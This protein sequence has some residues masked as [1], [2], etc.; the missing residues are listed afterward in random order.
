MRFRSLG[1][2]SRSAATAAVCASLA[3]FLLLAA[4]AP[5]ALDGGD[6]AVY[7]Q[8][9]ERGDFAQRTVHIGYYFAV[10][11]LTGFADQL[12]DRAFNWTSAAFA[13]GILG[14]LVLATVRLALDPT[15]AGGERRLDPS[16]Q[17]ASVAIAA[18]LASAAVLLGSWT[19]VRQALY[20]EVYGAQTFF[21]VLALYLWWRSLPAAGPALGVA[22]RVSPSSALAVLG[23]PALRA[24][25]RRLTMMATTT[26]ATLALV[27]AFVW[28]DFFFSDR[29]V[30][31]AASAHLGLKIAV[32]KEGFELVF[33]VFALLPFLFVG[34]LTLVLEPRRRRWLLVLGAIW[35]PTFLLGER[36]RDVP[37]QLPLWTLMAPVTVL[38]LGALVAGLEQQ[39]GAR[40]RGLLLAVSAAAVVPPL[41]VPW[42]AGEVQS[43]ARL[44]EAVPWLAASLV[45]AGAVLAQALVGARPRHAAR[46]LAGAALAA[47]LVFVGALVAERNSRL[48]AYKQAVLEIDRRSSPGWLAVGGW[49]SGIL[50]EHYLWSASY[51]GRWINSAWLAGGWS[52][53]DQERARRTLSDALVDGREVWLLGDDEELRA[54]L[55]RHRYVVRPELEHLAPDLYHARFEPAAFGSQESQ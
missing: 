44:P 9:I 47:N 5:A 50:L 42:A 32:L 41:L 3:S 49:S 1:R 13:A 51:T 55:T 26:V 12:S 7:Q 43:F 33:G 46:L 27:L 37:V 24:D 39:V 38:G 53:E 11:V 16:R 18:G 25:P 4:L 23:F 17:E 34:A 28:R 35:L 20:A 14:L 6:A 45:F 2:A 10:A 21:L 15:V 29:G 8:Q 48:E 52:E 22:G 54:E 30:A 36:F 19:F 40:R 31:Q